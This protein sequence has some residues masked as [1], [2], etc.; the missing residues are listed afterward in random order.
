M[1]LSPNT[2]GY[3][4]LIRL[5]SKSGVLLNTLSPSERQG[6]FCPDSRKVASV[7]GPVEK[8]TWEQAE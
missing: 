7:S 2:Q 5:G 1:L 8:S 3:R 4:L 6:S